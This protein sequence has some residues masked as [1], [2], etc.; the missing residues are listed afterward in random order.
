MTT[1]HSIWFLLMYHRTFN[2]RPITQQKQLDS[3]HMYLFITGS[4]NGQL[5]FCWLPSVVVCRRRRLS[6]V[7]LPACGSAGCQ[8]R[9][10]S[11]RRRPARGNRA[12]DTARRSSTVT[13]R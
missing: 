2:I 13:S 1:Y 7:T 6:S 11:A 8:A 5:L 3:V 12:A 9:G 4:P 10:R